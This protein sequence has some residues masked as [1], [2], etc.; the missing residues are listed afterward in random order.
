MQFS[1]HG[2]IVCRTYPD[3]LPMKAYLGA[4]SWFSDNR[5]DGFVYSVHAHI[6]MFWIISYVR[7]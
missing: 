7:L 3:I 6:C 1:A 2:D 4:G 5:L